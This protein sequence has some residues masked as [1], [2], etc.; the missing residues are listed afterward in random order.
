MQP[1]A[2]DFKYTRV[3][4]NSTFTNLEVVYQDSVNA[5]CNFSYKFARTNNTYYNLST[6]PIGS[7][8]VQATFQFQDI[9]NEVI[10]VL[11]TDEISG[12]SAPYLLTI[13]AFPLLQQFINFSDGTYGTQGNFGAVDLVT[14]GVIIIMMVGFNRVNESVGAIFAVIILG[15]FTFFDIVEWFSF[16]FGTFAVVIMLTIASTRKM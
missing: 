5:S 7:N 14:L 3:D 13:T 1:D 6:V 12:V 4:L 9:Q 16:M 10:A 2:R 15:F 8:E 11:C